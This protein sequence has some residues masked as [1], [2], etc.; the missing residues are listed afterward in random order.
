MIKLILTL[1]P[2]F[3]AYAA[4]PLFQ[5]RSIFPFQEKHVHGSSIIE[6]ANGDL[7]ACWFHGSGERTANDVQIQGSRLRKNAKDWS[8]V[9]GMAD[10]PGFPD[11]NPVLFIDARERLWL[12]WLTVLANQWQYSLLK[13]RISED[14]QGKEAPIWQWQDVLLLNPGDE[15]SRRVHDGFKEIARDEPMWAEYAPP[16][17]RMLEEASRD[18]FKRQIGWM[19]R[20]HPLILADGRILLPLYSDGFNLGLIAISDDNGDTWQPSSPIV[21]YGPNQPT[22]VQKKDGSIIAYMRDD[23]DA[24][25]RVLV[26]TSPDRGLTWS[27]A[28]DT[29]IPNPGSSLE[30]IALSS[31]HWLM[32]HNDTEEG[33]HS[34]V[35]RISDDQGQTWRWRRHIAR[36]LPGEKSFAYPSMIQARDG[37]IHITFSYA[38]DNNK[39]IK[40]VTINE[41]WIMAGDC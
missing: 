8:P 16:Y 33:R 1:L 35:V 18:P 41:S 7:L 11:C 10:T 38:A 17:V 34:L 21:G 3:A 30:V 27:P 26:S 40:H 22:L 23:G 14:Y 9:F 32:V 39:T 36:A 5:E 15:F 13:Y 31:G 25:N 2:C 29:D 6:C 12:V 19:T 37:L 28:R 20:I 24:P 4:Q